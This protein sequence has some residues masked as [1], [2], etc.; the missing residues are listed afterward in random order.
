MLVSFDTKLNE[1][2]GLMSDV[3]ND[4]PL[5][6]F[7]NLIDESNNRVKVY[8]RRYITYINKVVV[9]ANYTDPNNKKHPEI[10]KI[11]YNRTKKN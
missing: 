5:E 7:D 2:Y 4:Y 9:I 3:V 6:Y 1:F 10:E 11:I 8:L